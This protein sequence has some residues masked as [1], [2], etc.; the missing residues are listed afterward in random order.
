MLEEL[1]SIESHS[2]RRDGVHRVGEVVVG[3]LKEAGVRIERVPRP[4]LDPELRWLAEVLSPEV[5][6]EELADSFVGRRPGS[7]SGRVLLLGDL[8]TA[9]P[10]GALEDFPFA[11]RGDRA[12]GPGVADMKGGLVVLVAAVHALHALDLEAP[13]LSVVLCGDEQAGSMGSRSL[14]EREAG[15]SR[16]C[17]CVECARDGGRLMSSRAHIGVGLVEAKGRGAHAGT[18]RSAGANAID[19]LVAALTAA[20]LVDD[21]AGASLVTATIV[22]GGTRRS[23]VPELAR[24]VLDLRC[25]DA[26]AWEALTMSLD[27]AVR[28]AVVPT[29]TEVRLR[30][31]AH[32]P[33]FGPEQGAELL[34]TVRR[35]GLDIGLDL[36]AV[37][38]HAAGSSSFAAASGVAVVDGM[39]PSGGGLMTPEESIDLRSLTQRAAVLAGVMHHLARTDGAEAEDG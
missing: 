3:L 26:A 25:P 37:P 39:G 20:S 24:A 10:P 13:P 6:D 17:L 21:P 1:V 5:P 12:Y 31:A 16:W 9:F 18:A 35:V 23:M 28:A 7:D 15:Q 19:A 8:D 22:G 29:G 38:S 30:T 34:A 4:P 11:T 2:F 33:G 27:L 36:Q 14:V 32:R